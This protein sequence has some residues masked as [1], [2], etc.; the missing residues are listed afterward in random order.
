[1]I[2]K[3]K[4]DFFLF[5]SSYLF[6]MFKKNKKEIFLAFT[7]IVTASFLG[8]ILLEGYYWKS[9]YAKVVCEICRFHPQLGWETIPETT[10]TNGKVTY[11]T[12]ALGMRSPEVDF[13]R[14]HILLVGD[15]VT[16]GLG[17]NNDE[18]VSHFLQNEEKIS[19]FNFQVLN[20]G[21]PGYGI[22]QYYLNLKRHINKLNPKVIVLILYTAND[23]DE[24]RKD[25]R[26]G[27]S[28]PFFFYENDQLLDLNPKISQFSCS[29]I[30]ARLRFAQHLIP[31]F[32]VDRCAERVIE[33]ESAQPTIAK[34]IHKIKMLGEERNILTLIVLSPALTAVESVACKN[35]RGPE[36]CLHFDPG[37]EEFYK[38]FHIIMEVNKFTYV[39]FLKRL[40]DY[41]KEGTVKS[42][43]KDNGKDIHHFSPQGN[44]ILAKA[45]AE[46]IAPGKMVAKP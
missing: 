33:R 26:Y 20:F 36:S 30:Y 37:F 5:K 24:T 19:S 25:N 41:S 28:K 3:P 27:I 38:Y 8:L 45:I 40:V 42:L 35:F 18:T 14:G 21:V 31:Q 7:T 9:G 46:R 12:N 23:L 29:N 10:V 4:P 39:D 6:Q 2:N 22:G 1:M 15:S 44:L 17:V 11:T 43:Y 32:I 34:L 13:S 16:F